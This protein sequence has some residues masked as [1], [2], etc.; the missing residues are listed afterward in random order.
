MLVKMIK[1]EEDPLVLRKC[2]ALPNGMG[3]ITILQHTAIQH[4][5]Y[6]NDY[7]LPSHCMC[8]RVFNYLIVEIN[9]MLTCT[10]HH[11]IKD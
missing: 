10:R 5:L 11:S 7:S 2:N 9:V 6:T 8:D 1:E 4:S 3:T